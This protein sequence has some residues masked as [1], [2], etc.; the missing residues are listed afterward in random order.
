MSEK[1]RVAAAQ[2]SPVF[3]D[4][5]KTIDKGIDVILEA[6]RNGAKL[7]AFPETWVP[8]YPMWIYGAAGWDD[9]VSKS[10]YRQLQENSVEVPS[11]ATNRLC[12][13]AKE[14]GVN[15]VMGINERDSQYSRG[16]LYNSLLYISS[17]GEILGVR[18]K[19]IPTHTERLLWG[20]GDG[21]DLQ[22]FDTTAGRVG[23]TICWEHWMP[24]NRFAMHSLGEQIHVA[25]WPEVPDI[26]HLASRHYAFEGRCFVI[27]V[28]S[29]LRLE[30]VPEDFPLRS[31]LMEAG[32][33]AEDPDELLPG[34]SGVIGPDGQWIVGPIAGREEIIYAD[35]DLSVI[36]EEQFAFD[37]VGHYNRPDVFQVTID[38][39]K[40]SQVSWRS[41]VSH[42]SDVDEVGQ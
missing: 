3:L 20:Q 13:A 4:R 24:L 35:I 33:F 38:K 16:T 7:V 5:D 1:V 15:V 2:V 32:Q 14:A 39:T 21:S 28:G 25:A 23:G 9:P 31:I 27:C 17:E 40:R 41:S 12:A 36:G 8:C 34:G 42:D 11:P 6:G 26:H 19:L 29:Y 37:S 10:V 18:R 30:D 22:V